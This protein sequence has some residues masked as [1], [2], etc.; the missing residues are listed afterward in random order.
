MSEYFLGGRNEGG[1]LNEE[2]GREQKIIFQVRYKKKQATGLSTIEEYQIDNKGSNFNLTRMPRRAQLVK[3]LSRF[4]LVTFDI[5]DTL[6]RFRKPPGVQYAETAAM[7]GVKNLDPNRLQKVFRDEFKAMAKKYPN[8]GSNSKEISWQE[9]WVQLV[10]NVFKRIDDNL[11]QQQ[12]RGISERLF[13]QYRSNQCY[14]HIEGNLELLETIRSTCKYVGVISNTDP[15][16][17][18]VL[19]DM[20][21]RQNFDFV[22]TSYDL[23]VEKPHRGAFLKPLENYHLNPQEALHIGNLYEKDYLGALNAGWSGLLVTQS[24]DEAKKA[25][26]TQVYTSL[27]EMHNALETT[28]IK[29]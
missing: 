1:A 28:D 7:M 21:I 29:W 26:P 22:Y 16:L 5:T 2:S 17:E 24:M 19:R 6:L 25:K 11:P 4:K 15:G 20:N 14:A 18:R 9:W 3:N 23:G 8:F 27:K 13:E 12:I 10:H